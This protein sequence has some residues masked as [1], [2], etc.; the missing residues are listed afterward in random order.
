MTAFFGHYILDEDNNPVEVKDVLEWVNW[1]EENCEKRIVAQAETEN[2]LVSTIFLGLDHSF[3]KDA[4]PEDL[5]LFET[6]TFHKEPSEIKLPGGRT[7]KIHKSVD[8]YEWSSDRCR[9]YAEAVKM[10]QHIL[11]RVKKELE[12]NN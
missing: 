3:K 12:K 7:T 8:E 5:I 2:Y 1:L 9:T 6:M 4:E 11:E 10:H